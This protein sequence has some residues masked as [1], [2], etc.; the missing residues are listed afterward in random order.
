[1]Q[2]SQ[3]S[4]PLCTSTAT[5]SPTRNSSTSGPSAA[6]VPAYSWPMTNGPGGCPGSVRCSTFTSVPQIDAQSTFISTSPVPGSATVILSTRSSSASCSTTA[7]IFVGI[8]IDNSPVLWARTF[9]EVAR[10]QVEAVALG[11]REGLVVT[12][13]GVAHDAGAGIGGENA[14]E[15]ARGVRGAVG[16]HDH[17]RVDRVADADAAAVVH[18]HP[19]GAR[20]CVQERVQDGPV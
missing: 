12:G 18:A 3:R 13:V 5:R 4:Q 1:M 2:F 9:R 6:T 8:A 7:F 10:R 20:G 15:T 14:L 11:G 17:A 19:G 16:D